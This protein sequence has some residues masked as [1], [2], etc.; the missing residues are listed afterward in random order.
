VV[1]WPER[2]LAAGSGVRP[3]AGADQQPVSFLLPDAAASYARNIERGL[4]P[5]GVVG[6]DVTVRAPKEQELRSHLVN[7]VAEGRAADGESAP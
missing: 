5:A 4:M 1:V 2:N 7:V 3:V 6:G